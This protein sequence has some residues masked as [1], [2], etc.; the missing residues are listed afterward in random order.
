LNLPKILE[1]LEYWV[2]LEWDHKVFHENQSMRGLFKLE[3]S[4]QKPDIVFKSVIV[5]DD[6]NGVVVSNADC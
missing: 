3:S 4:F 2:A 5:S 1:M 6:L